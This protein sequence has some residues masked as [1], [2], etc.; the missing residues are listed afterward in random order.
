MF[1]YLA[2]LKAKGYTSL[3]ESWYA[4]QRTNYLALNGKTSAPIPAT[5][6]VDREDALGNHEDDDGEHQE[7][8]LEQPET[9]I[10]QDPNLTV[11]APAPATPLQPTTQT[12]KTQDPEAT[13]EA[14]AP[15]LPLH[16][17]VETTAPLAP[18]QPTA[19][20][21]SD[22]P[23]L[24]EDLPK[25]QTPP[26]PP[27]PKPL[28][29]GH[30]SSPP[31]PL[32]KTHYDSQAERLNPDTDT[33]SSE[34]GIDNIDDDTD[35]LIS[36]KIT[37][38]GNIKSNGDQKDPDPTKESAP[39][40]PNTL[41]IETCKATSKLPQTKNPYV[42]MTN[43][44]NTSN[45]TEKHLMSPTPP[46][47]MTFQPSALLTPAHPP[48]LPSGQGLITLEI[49]LLRFITQGIPYKKE[50]LRTYV[51]QAIKL[52]QITINMENDQLAPSQSEMVLKRCRE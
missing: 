51:V 37:T 49:P 13:V 47:Q 5:G 31:F 35:K 42:S 22:P 40:T 43:I 21:E 9:G 8:N 6:Q 52:G 15:T 50:E 44:S 45:P 17:T 3:R 2:E 14:P 39:K 1:D 11:E 29:P 25:P 48:L 34:E 30:S 32:T 4:S 10:T 18:L 46:T 33:T 38:Q 7:K 23:Q 41:D 19:Q 12:G 24:T 20:K 26:P 36:S 16:V 28:M 27:L